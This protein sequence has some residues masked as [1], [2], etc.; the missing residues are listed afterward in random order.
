MRS[1]TSACLILLWCLS[2]AV[3]AFSPEVRRTEFNKLSKSLLYFDDAPVVF[4]LNDG[5]LLI[6][7]DSGKN[8]EKSLDNIDRIH[9]DTVKK[10]R[11]F[12]FTTGSTHYVTNNRGKSWKEFNVPIDKDLTYEVNVNY[13]NPDQI[14]LALLTCDEDTGK[15]NSDIYYTTDG[16]NT[17]PKIMM[18]KTV[19]CLFTKS[20]PVF[21]SYE[22]SRIICLKT[23]VDKFGYLKRSRLLTSTDFF[24]TTPD[25]INDNTDDLANGYVYDLQV[26]QTFVVAVVQ[27]DRYDTDS[28]PVML[29]VSKDGRNFNKAILSEKLIAHGF[30]FLEST[31]HSLHI[32]VW[33]YANS[34]GLSSVLASDTDGLHYRNLLSNVETDAVGFINMDKVENVEGVW[35]AA[36][37]NGFDQTSLEPL[38]RSKITFD[39]GR[40]WSFMRTE[41]CPGDVACS[42]NLLSIEERRGDGQS[43]SGPT[44]GLLLGVGNTGVRLNNDVT[45]MH[46]YFS[47]DGGYSWKKVLD[48]PTIFSFGDF[49]NVIVAAPYS[50]KGD[51]RQ[52]LTKKLYYSLDQAE[53]WE[54]IELEEELFPFMLTTAIDGS[55]TQFLF[56]GLVGDSLS[57]QNQI[58][59]SLDF[60][61]AF[62][63]SCADDDFERWFGRSH[64]E[65]DGACLFGHKD[66]YQRRKADAKCF[67]NKAW[68]DLKLEEVPCECTIADYEC[69]SGLYMNSK[70]ECVPDRAYFARLC[71]SSPAT[72]YE[73]LDR[74]KIPGNMCTGGDVQINEFIYD[75]T[76][77]AAK[78][79]DILTSEFSI[80]GKITR[81]L[82][83]EQSEYHKS[84]ETVLVLNNLNQLFISHDGGEKFHQFAT[85]EEIIDVY[86]NP[87]FTDVAYLVTANKKL[88]VS[89]DRAATFVMSQAPS[90]V[91]HFGFPALQ[92]T[93]SSA[94]ISVF[95]G[96]EGCEDAWSKDCRPVAYLSEDFGLH[97][98]L[99][100]R[101]AVK[102]DYAGARSIQS[103]ANPETIIC[104]VHKD[105]KYSLV[106]SSD[107]FATSQTEFEN[108]V[109]FAT[110]G[111]FTVIA[112]REGDSLKAY[113]TG[114]GKEFAAAEFPKN[115]V[116]NHQQAYTVLGAESGAIFFHVTTNDRAGSEF[117][118]ILK[119]NAN[120]T[121]YV[122]SQS[123]VNRD[124][125]GFVDYEK[126]EGLEGIAII[127][128]VSNHQEA[129]QG[130]MKQLQSKITFND[131]SDWDLIQP[132][133]T[134][135]DGNVYPCFG[136]SLKE[137][138][139]H[140]HGYTE[141]KDVRDTFSSGS[142]TGLLLA[143]G[144]VGDK[145]GPLRDAATF[146]TSDG[147]S[148]WKEVKKGSY[149]WEFGD[150][151]SIIALVNDE[152]NTNTLTYSLDEGNTWQ[153]YK[154]TNDTV[155]IAD[156]VTVPSDTSK[157]FLLITR[158]EASRGDESRTFTI[159]FEKVFS[160]Q[161]VLDL[162]YP[163]SDDFEYWSPKHPFESSNCLFGHE[164]KYLR[165][166]PNR[167]DCFI[168]SAPLS[169][170]FKIERDCPC[171]RRDFECDYN[172]AK[173]E[174]GTCKLVNGLQPEDRSEI[175]RIDKNAVEYFE[176]TGY[177]K[178]P[179]S[180]CKGG[181]EFDKWNPVPCPGKEDEFQERHGGKLKGLGL[182]MV[183][184]I[185]ILV[186]IGATWFVYVKGIRRNGGFARFGE[187]RLGEED[188]LIENNV[189]DKVVNHIVR[190][191]ITV[192]AA[193]IA[194]YKV[195]R[196]MDS[197]VI[198]RVKGIF[199]RGN[200]YTARG[201]GFR[202]VGEADY[203]DEDDILDDV[204]NDEDYEIDDETDLLPEADAGDDRLNNADNAEEEV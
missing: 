137:C 87:Y 103:D 195:I 152:E 177:R 33:G 126:V 84:D 90:E 102:C 42:L 188:D 158:S 201:D 21:E 83:L 144:N 183:I 193:V 132:P 129:R 64:G 72:S 7:E 28:G 125:R 168:G 76:Q 164:A 75:C 133:S 99:L 202:A 180:T 73:Y 20:T 88:Y 116:V 71:S 153:D 167:I 6:S 190:G 2:V 155:K 106:S 115:F 118:A 109:G 146:L 31:K 105:Q 142:A 27:S 174:D 170:G 11:A 149:Q 1:P 97:W 34:M 70:G 179:M 53:T 163:D 46:T 49:G 78:T 67:I 35:I 86:L 147:G 56:G 43:A 141:R 101:D 112:A 4:D 92:F 65:G 181:Q 81:Y 185:P 93:N 151:G 192:I 59:Y 61:R 203:R 113:V 60:S 63:K 55:M 12:A 80:P 39:D 154:F 162:E 62:D 161:C 91:N 196:M 173:A 47:R 119:S 200:R 3:S 89:A 114:D 24:K 143:R 19:K 166:L 100:L 110:T 17:D 15:C 74:K 191:G 150:R 25:I 178:I 194:T 139:L 66:I 41:D 40:T 26:I 134:D 16:F 38:V 58:L 52:L 36:V 45:K 182:A 159:N 120:G 82:F 54:T 124:E 189:T 131:G 30:E 135:S 184:V 176:P 85:D 156:I 160:R 22:D 165:K 169:A 95:F 57:V 136:K 79:R 18:E 111:H 186:F 14:L 148:T 175:C 138:S 107:K 69:N 128:T 123:Q 68:V 157:K 32:S 140:L 204:L 198:E 122:L 50:K 8:W 127:N 117:G 145:L 187:I 10:E 23:E 104:Q 51:T 108:I 44:P 172:Y 48:E 199:R 77:D 171:T 13:A 130:A 197:A 5:N 37:A 94:E 96:Q 9:I 29:Y 98:Q 121:S